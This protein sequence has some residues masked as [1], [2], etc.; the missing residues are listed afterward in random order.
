MNLYQ[1]IASHPYD[2]NL[3]IKNLSNLHAPRTPDSENTIKY[4]GLTS[5]RT[6][7]AH[8]PVHTPDK[9]SIDAENCNSGV[10][11]VCKNQKLLNMCEVTK[12]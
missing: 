6:Q 10:R 12:I 2:K 7:I 11:G 5:V 9:P 3:I 4:K 8:T 1:L